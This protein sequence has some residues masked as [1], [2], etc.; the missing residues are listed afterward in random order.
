VQHFGTQRAQSHRHRLQLG[1]AA[2]RG[3]D[4]SRIREAVP[5]LID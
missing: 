4:I 5:L 1:I 3:L 2:M